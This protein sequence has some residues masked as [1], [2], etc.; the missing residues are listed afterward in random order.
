MAGGFASGRLLKCKRAAGCVP[1]RRWALHAAK[2]R[3]ASLTWGGH[4]ACA[5]PEEASHHTLSPPTPSYPLSTHP[6]L[7]LQFCKADLADAQEAKAATVAKLSEVQSELDQQQQV[8]RICTG[9]P[10]I[11][12]LT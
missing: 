10:A 1:P 6:S 11:L 9:R 8:G 7:P 2:R 4:L 12:L 3:A 5:W